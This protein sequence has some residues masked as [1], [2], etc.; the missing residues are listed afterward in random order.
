MNTLDVNESKTVFPNIKGATNMPFFDGTTLTFCRSVGTAKVKIPTTGTIWK[1]ARRNRILAQQ[2]KQLPKEQEVIY[3]PWKLAYCNWNDKIV[4]PIV[5]GLPANRIEK[6]PVFYRERDQVHLSFISGI[7][8][9]AGFM[10][11]LYTCSGPDLEHLSTPKPVAQEPLFFGFVSPHHLCTGTMRTIKLKERAT[12]LSFKLR[13]S[14]YRVAS[15]N[16][17]ADHP[18]QL[19]ITGLIDKHFHS[20][21]VIYDLGRSTVSLIATDASLYKA[22]AF[23]DQVI[24]AQKQDSEFEERILCRSKYSLKPSEISISKE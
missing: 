6:S 23:E 9:S 2:I 19:V 14:F 17:L 1:R 3:R 7:P 12:G 15:V 16:F 10:Y 22:T 24:F 4:K 8:T 11:R 21:S 5:T 20:Q 13:T 18:E